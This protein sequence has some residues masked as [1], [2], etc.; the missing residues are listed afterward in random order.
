LDQVSFIQISRSKL[1]TEADLAKFEAVRFIRDLARKENSVGLAQLA[2]RMTSVIR[3]D[4]SS[5]SDPF[6]KVKALIGDMIATLEKDAKGEASQKAYCDK[7][8]TETK[9]KKLEKEHEVSKFSTKIDSMTAN[10]AKLKE[11]V[12]ELQKELAALA[13]SEA[14]MNKIRSEE[15]ALYDRNSA[16]M[17]AGI[18]GVKKALSVLKEFYANKE[19]GAAGGIVS[20]L[21][22]VESDFTKGLSEME[23]AESSAVTEYEK[24]TYMNKV[25][26]TS[27]GQDA[28][29]KNKEATGLDKSSAEAVSDR[30]GIQ[31][32][33]DALSEYLQKLNNMCVAKAEPY[34]EKKARR[35]AELAGLKE[36]LQ[37]LDGE[38][39]LLQKNSRRVVH[40]KFLAA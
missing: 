36:A 8:T 33:L 2:S 32:E 18:N 16:E 7:E 26:K 22:I 21:E 37:I 38:A 10:S 23:G 19:S 27:K 34:A 40:S 25:A 39:V 31:T 28:K 17:K 15:K 29:Y 4:E 11:Q 9:S 6:S 5:G 14:E 3:F 12:A 30:E 1:S 20:M 35:E 24:V 13:S